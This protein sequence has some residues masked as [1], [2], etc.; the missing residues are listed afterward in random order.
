MGSVF[1]Q[2]QQKRIQFKQFEIQQKILKSLIFNTHLSSTIRRKLTWQLEK[3]CFISSFVYIKNRCVL[4]GRAK[5]IYRYF[6]FSRLT[7]KNLFK[8]KFIPSL[9]KSSW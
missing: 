9:S 7:I 1:L 4:S 3:I 2:D 8:L 5:S 6:N